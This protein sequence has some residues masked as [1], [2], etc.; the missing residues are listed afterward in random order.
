MSNM[1]MLPHDEIETLLLSG[2]V[3]D[4]PTSGIFVYLHRGNVLWSLVEA[5][6]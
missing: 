2:Q 5:W 6:R 3:L 1:D 4:V